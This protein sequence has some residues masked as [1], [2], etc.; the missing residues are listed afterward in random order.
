M[1]PSAI[2]KDTRKPQRAAAHSVCHHAPSRVKDE[3]VSYPDQLE[4]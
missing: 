4:Y 2:I 3:D 1:K